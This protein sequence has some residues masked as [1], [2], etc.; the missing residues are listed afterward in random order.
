MPSARCSGP[1]RN[2]RSSRLRCHPEPRRRRR[3]S[4]FN[5]L[6]VLRSFASL[7]M[8]QYSALSLVDSTPNPDS[9]RTK[10]SSLLRCV[11]GIVPA[12]VESLRHVVP[13]NK[14]GDDHGG[15]HEDDHHACA[16]CSH[17]TLP[18]SLSTS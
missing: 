7:R 4:S 12:F 1:I 15:G 6:R 5:D 17:I 9:R 8:T 16:C 2:R 13:A 3:I 14:E 18:F 11:R 10:C